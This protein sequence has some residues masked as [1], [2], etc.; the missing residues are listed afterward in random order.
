MNESLILYSLI[1]LA[2]VF[3]SAI[4]QVLL[5]LSANHSYGTP[6]KE[7]LNPLVISAYIMFLTSTF[8]TVY[9]YKVVPLSFGPVLESTSYLY[10]TAFGALVFKEKVTKK[11]LLALALIVGGIGVFSLFG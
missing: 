1:L 7:Y 5:K 4:S 11:K 2:S 9:A 8:M 6:I 3:V 10:V